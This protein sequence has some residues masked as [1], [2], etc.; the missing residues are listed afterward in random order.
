M[1]QRVCTRSSSTMSFHSHGQVDSRVQSQTTLVGTKSRVELN[2]VAP[3]HLE[4]AGVIVPDDAELDDA[5]G[6]GG[7][8]EGS[9]VLRELLE[10][11][12]V[13]ESARKL[14]VGLLEL[15]LRGNVG[16]GDGS[17]EI[18]CEGLLQIRSWMTSWLVVAICEGGCWGEFGEEEAKK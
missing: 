15:G 12:A 18:S 3:V 9:P 7:D 4:V 11:G 16:H 8:L 1:C 10:Q 6:D 14:V 17:I 2:T 5:L 13:L